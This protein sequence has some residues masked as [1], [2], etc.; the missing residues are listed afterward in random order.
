MG[1]MQIKLIQIL[2]FKNDTQST[3]MAKL[4]WTP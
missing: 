3:A 1:S 2:T 4:E